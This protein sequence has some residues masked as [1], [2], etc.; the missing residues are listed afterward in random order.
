MLIQK[1][2][3]VQPKIQDYTMQYYYF[4]QILTLLNIVISLITISPF[5][6]K[7]TLNCYWHHSSID[8]IILILN[9]IPML[10]TIYSNHNIMN[11]NYNKLIQISN[12]FLLPIYN[13]IM[14][15]YII[16]DF[17]R[18]NLNHC[19]LDRIYCIILIFNNIILL[20]VIY[21]M[22]NIINLDWCM[23]I[24]SWSLYLLLI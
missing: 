6:Y 18:L 13:I 22:N 1:Y 10:I 16:I 2:T 17:D 24:H 11:L 7:P 12:L 14:L 15:Y 20:I 5:I 3:N 9:N 21:F 19:M 23:L 8:H 4:Y